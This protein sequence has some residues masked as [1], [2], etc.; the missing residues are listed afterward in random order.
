L[1]PLGSDPLQ[2]LNISQKLWQSML[3]DVEQ[4]KPQEACGLIAGIEN[5]CLAV[6]PISNTLHSPVRF[7]MEP[8]EQLETF[9]RIDEN[10]WELLAIYHSHPSGPSHPSQTDIAEAAYPEAV[11]L[12]WSPKDASWQCRG[13]IIRDQQAY[14]IP[15]RIPNL[16]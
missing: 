11:N 5:R 10:N 7:R 3:A 8:G 6:F 9:M 13:F 1:V 12:I 15:I 16:E 4:R 14:E 2:E